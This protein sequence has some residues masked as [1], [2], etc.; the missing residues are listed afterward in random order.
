MTLSVRLLGEDGYAYFGIA[1]LLKEMADTLPWK[2][3][4][5]L[6]IVVVSRMALPEVMRYCQQLD[7]EHDYIVIGG[8]QAR[9]V[10]AGNTTLKVAAFI[11]IG[12]PLPQLRHALYHALTSELK[13]ADV[14]MPP[15]F[16]W[17]EQAVLN[18]LNRGMNTV[19][20]SLVLGLSA[21]TTSNYKR[22]VMKKLRVPNNQF[23]YCKLA[24]LSQKK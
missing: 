14:Q 18:F 24:V 12:L 21:K 5:L 4:P 8:G 22:S 3:P 7:P 19:Q 15:V 20:I 2:I 1:N 6:T 16:T 10:F 23:L 17:R 13:V 9:T 11:D